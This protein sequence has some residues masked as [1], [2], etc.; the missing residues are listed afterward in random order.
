MSTLTPPRSTPGPRRSGAGGTGAPGAR[1]E[2]RERSAW[3]RAGRVL[4]VSGLV[5]TAYGGGVVTGIV[6]SEPPPT[7]AAQGVL[8]AAAT[9]IMSEAADP[10]SRSALERAA[11]DGMLKTLGDRW[12]RYLPP[13]EYTSFSQSL[14]GRYSGIGAWLRLDEQDHVVVGSVQVGSPAAMAGLA[15]GDRVVSVDSV[16]AADSTLLEVTNELRGPAGSPVTV[17]VSRAGARLPLT[18]VRGELTSDDVT[19]TRL[20]GQVEVVRVAAFSRGVGRQVRDVVAGVPAGSGIVLDLR[21]NP[22]GL[23]TEA[24]EVSGAFLSGGPVVSYEKRGEP[25]HQLDALGDGNTTV[26]LVVLVD[27]GTASAA[28]IVAAALQD[29]GRA[30]IVGSRTYGKGSVQEPSTLP[31]GS[32]LEITVGRY[33]TPSGKVIDGVGVQPDI[34]VRPSLDPQEAETRALE[35]LRGLVSASDTSGRG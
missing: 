7:P 14:E 34:A 30:V 18:I 35:V 33:R 16:P 1:R 22:G 17:A 32:A 21:N 27:D 13:S 23:L 26:P 6:G 11:L 20:A 25:T 9:R 24:V 19:V 2:L 15:A 10:V 5:V 4:L 28:E 3:G 29:R 31:D 8:D 12:S